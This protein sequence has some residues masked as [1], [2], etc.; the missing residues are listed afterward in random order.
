MK[1]KFIALIFLSGALFAR[2]QGTFVWDQGSTNITD[3]SR[4]LT[5]TPLAQGFT[6]T[7]SLMDAAA[8]YLI[9]E[10]PS[11]GG[12]AEVIVR[13]G[14]VT[15]AIIGTSNPETVSGYGGVYYFTFSDPVTLTPGT[16]YY[17]QPVELSGNLGAQLGFDFAR[18]GQATWGGV[19]Q[20]Q[21]NFFFEEGIQV[22]PEPSVA[23]L[24]MIGG[25]AYWPR[26]KRRVT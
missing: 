7:E 22:V 9:P 1:T 13:S 2:G 18:T 16:E 14:S 23:T 15:G 24:F 3:E 6:P 26:R 11:P 10:Y 4:P 5:N 19:S 20:P 21:Y 25:I 17:L 8:F 12:D